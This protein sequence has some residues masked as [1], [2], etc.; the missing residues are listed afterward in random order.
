MREFR[1]YQAEHLLRQYGFSYDEIVFAADGET[2]SVC[3][4]SSR[5]SFHAPLGRRSL[6]GE[7]LEH[8]PAPL[9]APDR[10]PTSSVRISL[11]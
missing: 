7:P 6:S 1:L 2:A 10:T 5:T 9:G 8:G 11:R 3:L 4:R